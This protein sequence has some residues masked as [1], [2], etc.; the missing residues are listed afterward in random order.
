M[1]HNVYVYV[2]I[3]CDCNA[4]SGDRVTVTDDRFT[5]LC[6][7]SRYMMLVVITVNTS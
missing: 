5:S 1:Q 6:V 3:A 4:A 7:H 2:P